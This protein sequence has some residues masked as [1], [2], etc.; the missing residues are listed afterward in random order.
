MATFKAKQLNQ[1]MAKAKIVGL[2]ISMADQIK[3]NAAAI[4]AKR[5][6][7]T[8]VVKVQDGIDFEKMGSDA[9]DA[10][11]ELNAEVKAERDNL[12]TLANLSRG[13]LWLYFAQQVSNEEQASTL[14]KSFKAQMEARGHKRAASDAS[15]FKTFVLATLKSPDE[16]LG[17]M[18]SSPDYHQVMKDLRQIKNDGQTKARGNNGTPRSLSD[19]GFAKVQ[20]SVARMTPKQLTALYK[21][22]QSRAKVLRKAGKIFEAFAA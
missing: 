8:P 1:E 15:D 10:T 12:N 4:S 13:E 19:A 21:A 17:V 22:G 3:A 5:K 20:A 14:A 2:N 6:N 18:A 9:A 11:L 7:L 16:V